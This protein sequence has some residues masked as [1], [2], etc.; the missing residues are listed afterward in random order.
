MSKSSCFGYS[1][2]RG[3][4]R[5][6]QWRLERGEEP[7]P[8]RSAATPADLR[9]AAAQVFE[10]LAQANSR[11]APSL[12]AGVLRNRTTRI[13]SA[14]AAVESLARSQRVCAPP[15]QE[16]RMSIKANLVKELWHKG[17]AYLLQG[18]T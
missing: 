8:R 18:Y 14:R 15:Q 2:P 6:S 12:V 5:T 11:A 13:V 9:A 7:L 17:I 16:S 1:H 10:A 3:R 4:A